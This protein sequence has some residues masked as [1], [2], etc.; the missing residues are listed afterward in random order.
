[1]DC[2]AVFGVV[3]RME[4]GEDARVMGSESE[5]GGAAPSPLMLIRNKELEIASVI[6]AARREADVYIENARKKAADIIAEA[7]RK[8]LEEAARI[9]A[10]E[11]AKAQAEA[12]III[13]QAEEDAKRLVEQAKKRA[14]GV[15]KRIIESLLSG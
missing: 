9:R 1:M 4:R 15:A 2:Q 14:P 3:K 8:G 10:E 13:A 6:E 5:Q 12:A 11:I 7:E